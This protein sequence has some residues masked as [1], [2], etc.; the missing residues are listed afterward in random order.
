MDVLLT[1]ADLKPTKVADR[2]KSN[3]C[4]DCSLCADVCPVRAI[5]KTKS[6]AEGNN[7]KLCMRFILAI[8][9]KHKKESDIDPYDVKVCNRC[10][11]IC[12]YA[13]AKL[14]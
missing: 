2:T 3:P 1:D 9:K 8:K 6:P 5:D 10:F 14:N 11:V 4:E 7:R 13:R 12:P